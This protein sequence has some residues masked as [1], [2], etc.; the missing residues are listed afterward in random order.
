MTMY[1]EWHL[2]Q[3]KVQ[4]Q[5]LLQVGLDVIIKNAALPNL[6]MEGQVDTIASMSERLNRWDSRSPRI[7]K[8]IISTD[9]TDERLMPG[10]TVEVE[11]LVDSV[12]DVLFVPVEALYNKEGDTYCQVQ[13]T[14]DLEERLIKTGRVSTSFVEVLEG[15]E[16]EDVVLLHR[17]DS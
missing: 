3:M 8:T 4:M 10:M 5:S 14:F 16:K 9:T 6:V 1:K 17:K 2:A 13:G 7:Y 12:Q 15:L 11:I